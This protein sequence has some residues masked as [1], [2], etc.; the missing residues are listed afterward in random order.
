M[1]DLF[2][3]TVDELLGEVEREI[4]MRRA[5]YPGLIARGMLRHSTA[6]RQILLMEAVA[7]NLKGQI[8]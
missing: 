5:V 8:R 1:S 4:T 6:K 2:P 3:P 7:E